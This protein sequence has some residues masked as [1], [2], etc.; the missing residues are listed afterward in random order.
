[1]RDNNFSLIVDGVCG[2]FSSK[3]VGRGMFNESSVRSI[4]EDCV[5]SNEQIPLVGFW[6]LSDKTKVTPFDTRCFKFLENI[7]SRINE[8]H[9]TG[10]R[11]T[12]ILA[13][14]HGEMNGYKNI[15][16][17]SEIE[18]ECKV[19]G[20]NTV[21]LSELWNNWGIS[22]H[23]QPVSDEEWKK[24]AIS[25]ELEVM[26]SKNS[27]NGDG[28]NSAKRYYSTR[29]AERIFLPKTFKKMIWW[30]YS[31]PKFQEV[32]PL[33]PGVYFWSYKPYRSDCPWFVNK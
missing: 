4:L 28:K 11:L 25:E 22:R 10:V 5:K 9:T 24:I 20:W 31:D 16:Y 13:D 29:I 15:Q 8:I 27:V 32:L 3:R 1:M 2:I 17:L 19:R 14:S 12:I 18:K 21:W 33:M 6:G 7:I 23:I 30:S 26:A